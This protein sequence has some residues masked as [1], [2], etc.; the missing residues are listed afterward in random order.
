MTGTTQEL[1]EDVEGAF[2][3]RLSTDARLLEQIRLDIGTG[4]IAGHV[5]VDT[6]E[7]ALQ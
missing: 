5:E 3:G 2:V 1:I 7:F 6:N 4:N